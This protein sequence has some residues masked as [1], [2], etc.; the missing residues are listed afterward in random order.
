MT[1]VM[2]SHSSFEFQ[3]SSPEAAAWTRR[4]SA[5]LTLSSTFIL[6]FEA[7][8]EPAALPFSTA[9]QAC[10]SMVAP[11]FPPPA[12]APPS[13]SL[14]S[15]SPAAAA[16]VPSAIGAAIFAAASSSSSAKKSS[17][18]SSST[19]SGSSS[20]LLYMP[21][22]SLTSSPPPSPLNSSST[23]L[24]WLFALSSAPNRRRF[25][26]ACSGSASSASGSCMVVPF[27]GVSI[28]FST[29]AK[30]AC[31]AASPSMATSSPSSPPAFFFAREAVAFLPVVMTLFNCNFNFRQ[32][33]LFMTSS[34]RFTLRCPTF[35]LMPSNGRN[36][37]RHW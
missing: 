26:C 13:T 35:L 7:A 30:S 33:T 9:A 23:A 16:R 27:A 5:F 3:T 32:M 31:S 11:A 12:A 14:S 22:S 29:L 24:S 17:S 34:M 20:A 2:T 6:D 1:I 18:L 8:L 25:F 36:S 15:E 28:A 37:K 10:L 19:S 4:A 21:D